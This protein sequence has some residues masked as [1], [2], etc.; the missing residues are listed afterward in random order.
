MHSDPF[1]VVLEAR[2]RHHAVVADGGARV[3][4]LEHEAGID[5]HAILRAHRVG[6]RLNALLLG[7]V[8]FVLAVRDHARRRR[9]RQECLL[10]LHRFQCRL[11]IVDVALE[12]RLARVGDRADADR[13]GRR[14]DAVARV[15]LGVEFGEALAVGAAR[16]R[17]G[18]RLDRPA[19]ESGEPLEQRTGTS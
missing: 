4:E 13:F 8:V 16:E 3:V 2:R 14:G 6:D 5:D 7:P 12:L 15:E 17:V 18:A 1:A 10:D 11:E 9:N 19:L